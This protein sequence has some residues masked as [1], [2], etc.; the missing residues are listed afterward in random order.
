VAFLYR[1]SELTVC[2]IQN[3]HV[4]NILEREYR[5]IIIRTN[6]TRAFLNSSIP[7]IGDINK[8]YHSE[9]IQ[10]KFTN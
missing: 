5:K 4:K 8:L 9:S 1:Q 7:D 2:I 10:Q 3:V 6:F